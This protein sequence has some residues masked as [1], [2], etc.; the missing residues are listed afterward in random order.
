VALVLVVAMFL[1]FPRLTNPYG[2]MLGV[3]LWGLAWLFA[4]SA[5]RRGRG[6]ARVAG[7]VSFV[8]LVCHAVALVVIALR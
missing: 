3:T 7:R 1:P 4:I 5:M 6:G 2:L 8:V